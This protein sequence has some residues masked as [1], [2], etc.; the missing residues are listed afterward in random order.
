MGRTGFDEMSAIDS[1]FEKR[2]A[3]LGCSGYVS[4]HVFNLSK[5]S[6]F[7]QILMISG[8]SISLISGYSRKLCEWDPM[9][10]NS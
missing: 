5:P 2:S 7:N 3:S 10:V 1:P 8:D 4:I 6:N 9:N